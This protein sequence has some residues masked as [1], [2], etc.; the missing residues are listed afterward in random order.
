MALSKLKTIWALSLLFSYYIPK[1]VIKENV[2]LKVINHKQK[3][4]IRTLNIQKTQTQVCFLYHTYTHMVCPAEKRMNW[5]K[6]CVGFALPDFGSRK[7][8]Q[9]W[10]LW[11]VA[12]R[13]LHVQKTKSLAAPKWTHYWSRLGQLEIMVSPM[14][15]RHKKKN[16]MNSWLYF[17]SP[18]QLWRGWWR[19]FGGCLASSWGQPTTVICLQSFCFLHKI[20]KKFVDH[21][22]IFHLKRAL[23]NLQEKDRAF[24]LNLK[25]QQQK[26]IEIF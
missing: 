22:Y 21:M 9:G 1:M 26:L 2:K 5:H 17:I 24:F 10:L 13:F 6:Y 16:L 23:G 15:N 11:E 8:L 3:I 4:Q 25:Q 19:S 7:A 14:D 20:Q 18:L 12:R